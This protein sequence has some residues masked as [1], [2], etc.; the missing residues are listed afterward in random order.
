MFNLFKYENLRAQEIQR[1][2][3]Q[4]KGLTFNQENPFRD[5]EKKDKMS[6]SLHQSLKNIKVKGVG[7]DQYKK[8]N[9]RSS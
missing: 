9:R 2:N 4:M 1:M 3:Q 5:E 7:S 6:R 8:K